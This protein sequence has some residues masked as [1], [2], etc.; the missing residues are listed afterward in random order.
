MRI[1]FFSFFVSFFQNLSGFLPSPGSSASF[2]T[3]AF[4][5]SLTER[6]QSFA[7]EFCHTQLFEGLLQTLERELAGKDPRSEEE[8]ETCELMR[9]VKECAEIAK[10]NGGIETEAGMLAVRERLLPQNWKLRNVSLPSMDESLPQSLLDRLLLRDPTE[11]PRL[12]KECLGGEVSRYS[13]S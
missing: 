11:F 12:D 2:D 1:S 13:F 7:E 4:I 3:R 6:E 10:K 5:A 8:R 9:L